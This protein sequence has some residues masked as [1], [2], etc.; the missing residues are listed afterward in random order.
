MGVTAP[1]A[2]A[3]VKK[4]LLWSP[5]MA[6]QPLQKALENVN[7]LWQY[8]RPPLLSVI[9]TVAP[10]LTRA[11]IYHIPV[12]PSQETGGL[13]YIFQHRFVCSDGAA[14]VQVTVESCTTYAGGATAWTS[15]YTQS[16]ASAGAGA[17]TTHTSSASIIPVA[18]VAIRVTYGAPSAGTRTDHH[19][20]VHP[21]QGAATVGSYSTGFRPFDDSV[22][23]AAGAPIHEEFLQRCAVS[24]RAVLTDRKQ[25]AYAFVQEYST[26]PHL[27]VTTA[28]GGIA[29]HGLPTTRGYLPGAF[30]AQTLY[31]RAI[32]TVDGGATASLVDFNGALLD[33][34][35]TLQGAMTATGTPTDQGANASHDWAL[36]I[37]NNA[38]QETRLLAAVAFWTPSPHTDNIVAWNGVKWPAALTGSLAAAIARVES[39]ALTPYAGTA[40]VFD[41]TSAT[42]L[43]TRYLG[44][45]VTPG[46]LRLRPAIVQ[47]ASTASAL[48]APAYTGITSTSSAGADCR[49]PW[50]HSPVNGIVPGGAFGTLSAKSAL[51]IADPIDIAAHGNGTLS[52]TLANLPAVEPLT[53][54]DATGLALMP[55]RLLED[56][57]NL[58]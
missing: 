13:R 1:T 29:G 49:I 2:F 52:T 31:L 35:G 21:G 20:L 48:T 45:M 24:S 39:A 41:G 15:V 6:A 36:T 32:A 38:A 54:S 14:T 56:M 3:V 40:H 19:L 11:T 50:A 22:L 28:K 55:W 16:V 4:G 26:T 8:H 33:A 7:Y 10:S 37:K 9:Y 30:G 42:G 51:S 27:V 44:A 12:M 47:T 57:E 43:Q 34:D 18:A 46:L 53:V 17:L 58:P 23:T 25:C 5:A